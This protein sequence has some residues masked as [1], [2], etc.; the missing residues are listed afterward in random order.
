[1]KK[2]SVKHALVA[3]AI[4]VIGI[5]GC[6][7]GSI[8]TIS[9]HGFDMNTFVK[10]LKDSF[11]N[12]AV[13]YSFAIAKDG[14]FVRGFGFGKAR[15][16]QDPPEQDFTELSRIELASSTKAIACMAMLKAL[17]KKNIPTTN[18]ISYYLPSNWQIPILNKLITFEDLLRHKTGLKNFSYG[19]ENIRKAMETPVTDDTTYSN[20]NYY[21]IRILIPYVLY[22]KQ[23]LETQYPGSLDW[24]TSK[25]YLDFIRNEIF[26][27]A[28]L[29]Y[30]DIASFNDWHQDAAGDRKF[31]YPLYYNFDLPNVKGS[32]DIPSIDGGAGGMVLNT[33]EVVQILAAYEN[34][35]LISKKMMDAM[36]NK[37]MGWTHSFTTIKGTGYRKGGNTTTSDK[38]DQGMLS[39]VVVLPHNIQVAFLSN[40]NNNTHSNSIGRIVTAYNK[41]WK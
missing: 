35:K 19:W 3:M 30:W 29:Q 8:D 21:L 22:G 11:D 25:M 13:G 27:P 2:F 24:G 40:S 39:Y 37:L 4:L 15:M 16:P 38:N 36:E 28:G 12:R 6:N 9:D 14:K 23:Y 20:V 32:P 7:K 18:V 33:K 31:P 41:A 5:T 34:E 17:E 1:M 10:I 26:K